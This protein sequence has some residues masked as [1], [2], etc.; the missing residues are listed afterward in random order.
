MGNFKPAAHARL[1]KCSFRVPGRDPRSPGR[2]DQG[3]PGAAQ[4]LC[5]GSPENSFFTK[6]NP[7]DLD[8]NAAF[9]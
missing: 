7:G 9:C 8:F 3:E 4:T 1:Q 5:P 2:P 6:A